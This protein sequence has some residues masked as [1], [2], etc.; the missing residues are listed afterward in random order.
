MPVHQTTSSTACVVTKTFV[1]V[2]LVHTSDFA[3]SAKHN[4]HITL[5]PLQEEPDGELPVA[6][7]ASSRLI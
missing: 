3:H 2:K 7:D 5:R 6:M 1:G 4:P